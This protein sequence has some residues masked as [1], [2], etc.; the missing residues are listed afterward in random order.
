MLK[1]KNTH[2][3]IDLKD[4][5]NIKLIQYKKS[6]WGYIYWIFTTLGLSKQEKTNFW[7]FTKNPKKK[8]AYACIQWALEHREN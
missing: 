5:E 6:S 2:T 3:E 4:L 8:D 7:T 1:P